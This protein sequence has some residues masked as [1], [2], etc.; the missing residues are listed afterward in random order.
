[1]RHPLSGQDSY[2]QTSASEGKN[3]KLPATGTFDPELFT[4]IGLWYV[5][6][7]AVAPDFAH[8]G[9]TSILPPSEFSLILAVVAVV[10]SEVACSH[11]I[12]CSL[13]LWPFHPGATTDY[14]DSQ[15]TTGSQPTSKDRISSLEA[16]TAA[17]FEDPVVTALKSSRKRKKL[18]TAQYGRAICH[19]DKRVL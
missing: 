4:T 7:Q 10:V 12:L 1:M 11:N 19:H 8:L 14:R 13:L 5:D 2:W 18:L 9:D 16:S 15:A 17:D 6:S 3:R